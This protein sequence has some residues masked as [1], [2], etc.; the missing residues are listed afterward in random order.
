MQRVS[1]ARV[2]VDGEVRGAIGHGLLVLVGAATGDGAAEAEAL[3]RKVAVLR[4]FPDEQG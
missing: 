4:V 3:A 1:E 2:R